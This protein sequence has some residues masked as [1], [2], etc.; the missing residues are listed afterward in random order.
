MRAI[1]RDDDEYRD[2]RQTKCIFICLL[3]LEVVAQLPLL[4]IYKSSRTERKS[5]QTYQQIIKL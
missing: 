1:R 2:V 3:P 4:K 5:M